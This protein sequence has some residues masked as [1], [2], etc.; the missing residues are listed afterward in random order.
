MQAYV[1][2]PEDPLPATSGAAR[3]VGTLLGSGDVLYV[4]LTSGKIVEVAPVTSVQ[5]TATRVLVLNGDEVVRS[6]PRDSVYFASDQVIE[7]PCFE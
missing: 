1:G 4:H 3:P 6:F 7:P 2:Q 5:L